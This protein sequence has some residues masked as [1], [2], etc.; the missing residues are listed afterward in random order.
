MRKL[1]ETWIEAEREMYGN[2]I[3]K[4]VNR[5]NE[6]LGGAVTTSRVSEWRRGIYCPSQEALSEMLYR[7]Y[8]YVLHKAGVKL[9]PGQLDVID[10]MLWVIEKHEDGHKTH[11]FL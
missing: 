7:G 4:A 11:Y 6:T 10:G 9:A 8:P 5:L 3:G 2:S 1:V